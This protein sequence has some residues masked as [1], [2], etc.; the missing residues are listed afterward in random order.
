MGDVTIFYEVKTTQCECESKEYTSGQIISTNPPVSHRK[1]WWKVTESPKCLGLGI[2][3]TWTNLPRYMHKP[4]S[5]GPFF[6]C[7]IK[8]FK[9]FCCDYETMTS[10]PWT[11]IHHERMY[12]TSWRTGPLRVYLQS[13]GANFHVLT[14]ISRKSG[15]MLLLEPGWRVLAA[16]YL[17]Q[18]T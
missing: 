4:S 14:G 11:A 17:W 7:M 2:I 16:P 6:P 8:S 3:D 18:L 9:E 13:S 1:W 5:K 10:S 15:T 12:Q